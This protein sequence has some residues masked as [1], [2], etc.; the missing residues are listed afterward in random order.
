[1][2]HDPF[3][4]DFV[5]DVTEAW[6]IKQEALDAYESQLYQGEESSDGPPTKV[7]SRDFRAAME[8]RARHF[9][10]VIGA[11]FGEP[12]WSPLPLAVSDPSSLL[13]G[14]LR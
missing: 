12:F 1:M 10:L 5:V 9:G 8:G 13:P 7:A 3:T 4:P 14:G 6:S 2:Q 11:T